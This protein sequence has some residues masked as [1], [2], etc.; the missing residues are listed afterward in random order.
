MAMERYAATFD[1]AGERAGRGRG[2][3]PGRESA[4][5][6]V[7]AGG[8]IWVSGEGAAA[9]VLVAAGCNRLGQADLPDSSDI[10]ICVGGAGGGTS[11]ADDWQA[12]LGGRGAAVR[13]AGGDSGVWRWNAAAATVRALPPAELDR[14]LM[15]EGLRA[16][17]AGGVSGR[18]PAMAA[19]GGRAR[20]A[21]GAFGGAGSSRQGS[22][23]ARGW[24]NAAERAAANGLSVGADGR[25]QRAMVRQYAV[26]VFGL[27]APVITPEPGEHIGGRELAGRLRRSS[28]RA[29]YALGLEL[30]TVTWQV[31]A[32]GR[33]GIIVGLTPDLG[34]PD[35]AGSRRLAQAVSEFAARWRRE[36]LGGRPETLLGADPE[37][38]ML[39]AAGRI[40]P[41]S[42]Y[43]GPGEPAGSDS[44]V[45][46]GVQR[47]PL[48]ELRPR[49]AREPAVLAQRIRRL[50]RDAAERTAGAGLIWRAGAA[51]VRGLPLGGHLHLSGV[52]LTAE[53]L[54]ALDN[55]LALPLRLLEPPAAARRRPRYGALGDCRTKPHGGFEYRTPPSWLVSPKLALGALA[56]A[57]LAA[58]HARELAACQPL[59][60]DTLRDAFYGDGDPALLRA[61]ALAMR[62]ALE[63]LPSYPAYRAAVAPLFEAI[64]AGRVWDESA[65][66]RLKWRLPD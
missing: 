22:G 30:G 57:K 1:A 5:E 8:S 60:D 17:I 20:A 61:A 15:R 28:A 62:A 13:D 65:D 33:R 37:F 51:P 40:V 44:V 52:A 25:L 66:I 58:E 11:G 42:R 14:R 63:A 29:I 38:V 54:R 23:A 9:D 39:T 24:A 27:E 12:G 46:R 18:P 41:A 31:D 43:F 16:A 53:R 10:V 34:A 45:V 6:R 59:R 19:S 3:E 55:A 4:S 26:T 48:A 21:R 64:A 7:G 36:R 50:L 32:S 2:A 47:W 56:L 35:E 49:P